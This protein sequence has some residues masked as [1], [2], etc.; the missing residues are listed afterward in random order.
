MP[1]LPLEIENLIHAYAVEL[2]N[3][4]SLPEPRA[5]RELIRKSNRSLISV[6][7]SHFSIP[8]PV[9]MEIHLREDLNT[10]L[11]VTFDLSPGAISDMDNLLNYCMH[12][13]YATSSVFWLFILRSP[14]IYHGPY[15]RLFEESLLHKL[16]NFVTS[17]TPPHHEYP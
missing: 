11:F 9:L 3:A 13:C 10:P 17:F 4:E 12:H 1:Q 8:L 5:I 2:G 7:H 15:A 6:G 14:N 16:L